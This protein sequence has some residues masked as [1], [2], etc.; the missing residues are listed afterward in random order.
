MP[1]SPAHPAVLASYSDANSSISYLL[2]SAIFAALSSVSGP[3]ARYSPPVPS[4][5]VPLIGSSAVFCLPLAAVTVVSITSVVTLASP[6]LLLFAPPP[7]LLPCCS[8]LHLRPWFFPLFPYPPPPSLR[9]LHLPAP[10]RPARL[11]PRPW[12]PI[13]PIRI[14]FL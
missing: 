9:L 7:S 10:L 5:L 11:L 12:P 14:K 2:H 3:P 4:Y 13:S 6:A 8:L 1:T